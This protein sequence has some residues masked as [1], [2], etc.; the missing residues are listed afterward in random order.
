MR[1]IQRSANCQ[2]YHTT[3]FWLTTRFSNSRRLREDR[4]KVW[5]RNS[6]FSRASYRLNGEEYFLCLLSSHISPKILHLLE[7]KVTFLENLRKIK[8]NWSTSVAM[9][10]WNIPKFLSKSPFTTRRVLLWFWGVNGGVPA[11]NLAI[12]KRIFKRP[13]CDDVTHAN[14]NCESELLIQFGF[15]FY[16][17]CLVVSR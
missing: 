2:N 10:H 4:G 16:K 7:R 8:A 17:Y 3:Q 6:T 13:Y 15:S 12:N 11:I 1:N 9:W 5:I 14:L